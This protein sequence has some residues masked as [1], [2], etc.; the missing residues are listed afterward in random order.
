M[1]SRSR[2]L[3]AALGALALGGAL[4]ASAEPASAG[5]RTGTWRNGMVAGPLGVGYYGYP[6]FHRPYHRRRDVGGAVAAGLIGGLALGALAA[7]SYGYSHPV[8]YGG[9]DR[10]YRYSRPVAYGYARPYRYSRPATYGGYYAPAF[11]DERSC[12][13]VRRRGV[14]AWGRAVVT[15]TEICD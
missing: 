7:G 11:Y 8:T 14:D 1:M 12:H 9:Y 6:R 5:A 2:T 3:S 13:V 10:P 15:R 4:M